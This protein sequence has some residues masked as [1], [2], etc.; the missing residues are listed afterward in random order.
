MSLISI[1]SLFVYF[2]VWTISV[3]W[4]RLWKGAYQYKGFTFTIFNYYVMMS[5]FVMAAF[6][7]AYLLS[8]IHPLLLFGAFALAGVIGETLISM[9]WRLFFVKRFW[10]YTVETV[11]HG[12]TSWLNFIPWAVGGSIYITI[13]DA[14][15]DDPFG[16]QF[17]HLWLIA[18]AFVCGLFILQMG[19]RSLL[20]RSSQRYRTVTPISFIL[21]FWP[22]A[23]FVCLLAWIYGPI[24]YLLA[25][26]F[27]CIAALAEYLLGKS[28][29]FFISKKLW[30]YSYFAYDQGHFTPLSIL[31]FTLGGFYFWSIALA[32]K[33]LGIY[34]V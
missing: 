26:L 19:L 1:S 32:L 2:L 3:L 16:Q 14:V 6:V 15:V 25:C 20:Y 17:A 33:E 8:S 10:V 22:I 30:T 5:A 21:F 11:E 24:I 29:E 7:N 4:H 18:S 13:L 23:A 34:H 31:F 27:G 12:Y 9:W 28:T